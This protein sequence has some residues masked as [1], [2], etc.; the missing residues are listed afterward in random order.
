VIFLRGPVKV[1]RTSKQRVALCRP[2]G[3]RVDLGPASS[4]VA[5]GPW[6]VYVGER[7]GE[8]D[9]VQRNVRTGER[10]DL[11]LPCEP[12][13]VLEGLLAD[14]TVAWSSSD[15]DEG[16]IYHTLLVWRPGAPSPTQLERTVTDDPEDGLVLGTSALAADGTVYWTVAGGGVH[17]AG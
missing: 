5:R 11:M 16:T 14:G 3:R 15:G 17:S 12:T 1:V 4:F 8:P 13:A 2:G 9:L 7:G 6:L 10:R